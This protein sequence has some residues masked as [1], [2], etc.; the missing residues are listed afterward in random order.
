MGGEGED[1]TWRCEGERADC[2]NPEG[3]FHLERGGGRRNS[4]KEGESSQVG[5][6][7]GGGG[8]S[9]HFFNHWGWALHLPL[10]ARRSHVSK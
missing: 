4:G 9:V 1:Q 7:G 5:E 10:S 8:G 3:S 6:V 2:R